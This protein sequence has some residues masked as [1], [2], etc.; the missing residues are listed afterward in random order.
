MLEMAKSEPGVAVQPEELDVDPWLLCVRNGTIDLRTGRLRPHRREDMITMLAPVPYNANAALPLWDHFLSEAVPDPQTRA[1]IQRCAGA[2]LAGRADDDVLLVCHGPGGTGKGTF[3]NGLQ[4]TLGDYAA[5]AELKTFTTTRDAHGPQPDMARLKGCRMVAISEINTGDS[6]TLLKNATGG[7]P[8]VTRNHHEHSYQFIPQFTLWIICNDRPRVPDNDTG[9]WRRMREIPFTVKFSTPDA[10]I[11]QK[12]T[13]PDIAGPA[14]LAWAVKG[15]LNWQKDGL[16][17]LPDQV[18]K[19]TEAY[20]ADMNPLTEWLEE[21][22]AELPHAWTSFKDLFADYQ[23]W[24]KEANI[25]RPMGRKHFGQRIGDDFEPK[26]GP[27]GARG[28]QGIGLKS[29]LGRISEMSPHA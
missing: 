22:T 3:L 24:A 1:Y 19:A 12:L 21:N 23:A 6:F 29:C 9:I 2:S 5:A 27:H 15:C 11:R 20:R 17:D 8:I 26:R 10:S 14:I 18:I 7:D 13:N 16:G 28:N 25:R 4:Q